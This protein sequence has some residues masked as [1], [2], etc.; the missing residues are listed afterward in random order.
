[1]NTIQLKNVTLIS[2]KPYD[3]L[4]KNEKICNLLIGFITQVANKS[5]E[6]NIT[7]KLELPNE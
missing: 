3:E 1:M 2:S 6:T 4:I 5:P 7:M